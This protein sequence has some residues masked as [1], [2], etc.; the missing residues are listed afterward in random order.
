MI[1]SPRHSGSSLP[2]IIHSPGIYQVQ[3]L[4]TWI[5]DVS[6]NQSSVPDE[7]TIARL[8]CFIP[9][10]LGAS[11]ALDLAVRCLTV[12]HFGIT[13]GNEDI[14]RQG[15]FAYGKA[16]RSLQEAIYDPLEAMRSETLC[17]T[18]ILTIYEVH[19][20]QLIGLVSMLT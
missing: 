13:E 16:L 7:I 8:F 5:E 3:C 10:R 12:H 17:A 18:M 15:Q 6:R 14:I 20:P 11:S 19:R 4:S 2:A 1:V 9:A